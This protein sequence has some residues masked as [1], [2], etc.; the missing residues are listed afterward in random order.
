MSCPVHAARLRRNRD[1]VLI[2]RA[3][4]LAGARMGATAQL[5][6]NAIK[7]TGNAI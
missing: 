5:A 4:L 1:P 3:L 6:Q 2:D 7:M